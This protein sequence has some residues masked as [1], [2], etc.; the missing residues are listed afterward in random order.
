VTYVQDVIAALAEHRRA[1][2]QRPL[3]HELL[4]LYALLALTTG[5][6]TTAWHVHDAWS[7]WEGRHG[8]ADHWSIV[9]WL[10]LSAE[11][12]AKDE[13]YAAM[14]RDVAHQLQY[15][16]STTT[17]E[18]IMLSDEIKAMM[19][20]ESIRALQRLVHDPKPAPA[21][22]DAPED[23][24]EASRTAA[25]EGGTGQTPEGSHAT[26]MKGKKLAGWVRG[27]EKDAERRTHPAMV[28]FN[29]LPRDQ[30]ARDLVVVAVADALVELEAQLGTVLAE[31]TER[32]S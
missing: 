7:I 18:T 10:E 5:T 1:R 19:I 14:I 9:P 28:P 29:E 3:A 21:W 27:D 26:W 11:V 32:D 17:G 4:E 25:R 12:A 6:D 16:S 31:L 20:H 22:A 8:R 23:M 24:R 15:P 30:W 2:G 13:Q